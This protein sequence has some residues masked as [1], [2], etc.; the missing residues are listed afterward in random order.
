MTTQAEMQE[1]ANSPQPDRS[2]KTPEQSSAQGESQNLSAPAVEFR[3]VHFFFDDEKVLDGISFTV[4]RGEI[5]VILSGSGGGKST[6]LK[7]ILGLLSPP[8]L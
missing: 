1:L 2:T 8:S 7:L 6:I 4:M 3:D 5:K